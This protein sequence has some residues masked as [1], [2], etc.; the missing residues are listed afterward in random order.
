MPCAPMNFKEAPDQSDS[1]TV[2]WKMKARQLMPMWKMLEGKRTF[3]ERTSR[4]RVIVSTLA[5]V[6]ERDDTIL[7]GS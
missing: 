7:D 1:L 3:H 6:A 2:G 5:C 4:G